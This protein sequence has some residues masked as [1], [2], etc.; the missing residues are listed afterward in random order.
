M[1]I[2][3][4]DRCKHLTWIALAEGRGVTGKIDLQFDS[5]ASLSCL[6]DHP[7]PAP[8]KRSL[9]VSPGGK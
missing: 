7:G 1:P 8:L 4:Y 3:W 2:R 9:L 6:L 5:D